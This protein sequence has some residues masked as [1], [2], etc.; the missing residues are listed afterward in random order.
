M[1]GI[2]F[3]FNV[4]FFDIQYVVLSLGALCLLSKVETHATLGGGGRPLLAFRSPKFT[5]R[6]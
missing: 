3:Y 5:G 4:S 1:L 2:L 6:Q